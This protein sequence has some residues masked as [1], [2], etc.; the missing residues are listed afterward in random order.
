LKGGIEQGAAMN[1]FDEWLLLLMN[2]VA[3]HTPAIAHLADMIVN[4]YLVKGTVPVALL[5]WI[6]FRGDH[7]TAD[8]SSARLRDREIVVIA[9]VSGLIALLLGR[10]LA[11]YLPFRLRPIYEPQL[12]Q[13][14]PESSRREM[15]PRTWSAFP[16]DHA[17][18]WCAIAAAIFVASRAA[19][20]YA[21]LH[22]AVFI[23]LPRIYLGLHY[24]TD[25]LAGAAL[26]IGIAWVLSAPSIRTRVASPVLAI[27]RYRPGLFHALAFML[28]FELATQFDEFRVLAHNLSAAI[29]ATL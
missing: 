6:W 29:P 19:G 15:L 20:I 8:K 3:N 23:A 11:H 18:L 16:S 22:T 10:L 2:R 12:R 14:Y 28:C 26:G 27:A 4:M 7:A 25:V 24:P 17:M 13:L 5:W 1:A 9:I 21:L